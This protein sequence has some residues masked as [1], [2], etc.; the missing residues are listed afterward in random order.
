MESRNQR[1][2]TQA[3][4]TVPWYDC[5]KQPTEVLYK[6]AIPKKF[7]ISTGNTCVGVYF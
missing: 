6:K 4:F 7:A 3:D 1:T 5:Q 2:G